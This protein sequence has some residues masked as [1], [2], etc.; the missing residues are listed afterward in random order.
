MPGAVAYTH[1]M[2]ETTQL[3]KHYSCYTCLIWQDIAL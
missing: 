3:G 1:P 2:S